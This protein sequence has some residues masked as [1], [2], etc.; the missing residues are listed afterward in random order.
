MIQTGKQDVPILARR[1][2]LSGVGNPTVV[3][4]LKNPWGIDVV[5]TRCLVN[6]TTIATAAATVDIGV[7]A[8][9]VTSN[10]G[11]LD[12]LDVHGGTGVFDNLNDT[13][14]GTNG[15]LMKLWP[16]GTYLNVGKAGGNVTGLVGKVLIQ[17]VPT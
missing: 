14:N 6:V 12:G 11:L 2:D 7:A 8:D 16:A 15:K 10:D 3:A 9:A 13:D 4:S 1:I 17:A 5:I